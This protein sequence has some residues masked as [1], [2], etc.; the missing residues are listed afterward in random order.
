MAK[1]TYVKLRKERDFNRMHHKRV[2][3]EKN[4][5]IDDIKR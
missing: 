5:L 3:Q 2:V 4:R 1:D